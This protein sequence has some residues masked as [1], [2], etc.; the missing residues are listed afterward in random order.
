MRRVRR[1]ALREISVGSHGVSKLHILRRPPQQ[2][3]ISIRP[4]RSRPACTSMIAT[5]CPSAEHKARPVDSTSV[6]LP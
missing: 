1:V 4:V 5:E 6:A 3:L 2:R